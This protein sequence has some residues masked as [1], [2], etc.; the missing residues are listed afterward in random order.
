MLPWNQMA[1]A[2]MRDGA[3]AAGGLMTKAS[4]TPVT[5][6]FTLTSLTVRNC[7]QQQEQ[8]AQAQFASARVVP[9]ALRVDAASL[10][11]RAD[12]DGGHAEREGNVS[13]GGGDAQFGADGQMAIRGAQQIEQRRI[14]RQLPSRAVADFVDG[15]AQVLRLCAVGGARGEHRVFDG[16]MQLHFEADQL[17]RLR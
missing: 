10:A 12:A 4:T 11:A 17:L 7:P 6:A 14:R 13:V 1:S 16:A 8:A 5:S 9:L 3:G 15:E 2:A